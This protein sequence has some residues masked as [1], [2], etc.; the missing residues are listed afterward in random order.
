MQKSCS[1]GCGKT[2]NCMFGDLIDVTKEAKHKLLKEKIKTRLEKE[3]GPKLDMMADMAVEMLK[4][5]ME[6]KKAKMERKRQMME[7]MKDMSG[8]E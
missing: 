8:E 2:G 3:I 1:C 4:G 7:K 6:M 5:K